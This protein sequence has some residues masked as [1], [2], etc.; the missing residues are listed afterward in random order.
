MFFRRMLIILPFVVFILFLDLRFDS[1]AFSLVRPLLASP[2][3]ALQKNDQ[4]SVDLPGKRDPQIQGLLVTV[5]GRRR[6]NRRPM[7]Q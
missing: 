5:W 2:L 6:C 1:L 3:K 7:K 4:R